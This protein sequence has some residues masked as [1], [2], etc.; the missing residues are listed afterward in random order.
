[1]VQTTD[2]TELTDR[3]LSA[4]STNAI[5][6][7]KKLNSL[8]F[9]QWGLRSN[10]IVMMDDDAARKNEGI[11]IV[12]D[13]DVESLRCGGVSVYRVERLSHVKITVD[14]NSTQS[15]QETN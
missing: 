13:I 7:T 11:A 10:H 8:G 9:T 1:M 6:A 15:T 14:G 3:I 4:I 2:V 5:T 12:L